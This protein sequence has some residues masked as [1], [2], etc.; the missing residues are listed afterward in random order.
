MIRIHDSTKRGSLAKTPPFSV[1]LY[2]A[3]SFHLRARQMGG[4]G[5]YSRHQYQ[6]DD[7]PWRNYCMDTSSSFIP[8]INIMIL[9]KSF[10]LLPVQTGKLELC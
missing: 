7:K 4:S 5:I 10:P 8:A 2:A 1:R 3:T 6:P 9:K